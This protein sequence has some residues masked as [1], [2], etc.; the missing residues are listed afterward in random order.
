M[1]HGKQ[2]VEFKDK[3][4]QGRFLKSSIDRKRR[5]GAGSGHNGWLCTYNVYDVKNNLRAGYTT[6]R[7]RVIDTAELE[8]HCL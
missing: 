6:E 5:P 8:Y 4:G 2:V 3:D 7:G 1:K